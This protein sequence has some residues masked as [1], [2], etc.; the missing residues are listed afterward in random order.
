LQQILLNLIGNAIKYNDKKQIEIKIDFIEEQ[1]YYKFQVRD[2]GTG[3]DPKYQHRIF[4][5]FEIIAVEDR[6]GKRGT[7]I[8]LS[9]VKKLVERLGGII[10]V[11]SVLDQG[12]VFEF[13][14]EKEVLF[15]KKS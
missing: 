15:E 11:N 7:G 9:T 5:I 8:G 14:I 10:S 4:D 12:T 1:D 3:I 2:N 6:F 13:T